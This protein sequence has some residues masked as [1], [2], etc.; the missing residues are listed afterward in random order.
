MIIQDV[1]TLFPKYLFFADQLDNPDN[2]D[3]AVNA[4]AKA[5]KDTNNNGLTIRAFDDATEEGVGAVFS[6][7]LTAVNI[8][9]YL[10]SRAETAAASNLDVVPKIYVR[11]AP[12]DAAVEAWSAGTDLTTITMGTN[13]EYFQYDSQI[14]ALTT[15][16]LVAG[17]TAQLELTRNTGS[18]SDTLV[19]DWDLLSLGIR[20]S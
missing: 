8:D 15:L 10:V 20:F 19:G 9:I 14:I 2:A 4:L 12:D 6:I 16:G 13:N 17:R 11:E 5:A 7:P 1:D 18:G 3:W